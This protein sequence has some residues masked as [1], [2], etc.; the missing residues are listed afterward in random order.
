M[1]EE[2]Q[3]L[4]MTKHGSHPYKDAIHQMYRCS[5]CRLIIKG[6]PL[7][8]KPKKHLNTYF[9]DG[10]Y[11]DGSSYAGTYVPHLCIS[12]GLSGKCRGCGKEMI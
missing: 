3:H 12:R 9:I 1:D 4:I 8:N 6:E 5:N 7:M 10:E 2:C 11:V